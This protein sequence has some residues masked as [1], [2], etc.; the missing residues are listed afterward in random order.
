MQQT[1]ISYYQHAAAVHLSLLHCQQSGCRR[2]PANCLPG[3]QPGRA[4]DLCA[5]DLWDADQL[6]MITGT[7]FTI[8]ISRKTCAVCDRP[9][10]V[11]ELFKFRSTH[12]TSAF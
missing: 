11:V 7:S 5:L 1:L 4:A 10:P 12:A 6:I 9:P 8:R 2:C 3:G